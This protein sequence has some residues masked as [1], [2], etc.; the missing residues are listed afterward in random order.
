MGFKNINYK[1][2]RSMEVSI[3]TQYNEEWFIKINGLT[4][5]DCFGKMEEE[6]VSDSKTDPKLS[7]IKN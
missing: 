2:T 1:I 5:F 6:I 7:K 4:L 3:L